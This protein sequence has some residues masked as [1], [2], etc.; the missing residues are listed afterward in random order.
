MKVSV[1]TSDLL[2]FAK[3]AEDTS[4]AMPTVIAQSLNNV[5]N[6]LVA[7]LTT[8]L[9]RDTGLTV[10]QVRGQIRVKRATK[11]DP[12][13][14]VIVKTSLMEDDPRTLEGKRES[15]DF[16]RND[17]RDLVIIVNQ[18]DD[19]VCMDCEELAAAGPMPFDIAKEHIPKHPHCRC[20]IMPF[21]QKGKRLPVT[22]TSTTGTSTA[23][24]SGRE[25]IDITIRQ[26]A[27]RIL[28]KTVTNIKIELK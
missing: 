12:T 8:D 13:Y 19:L 16:G 15:K 2:K 3:K 28:D 17:P 25:N 21:V 23:K 4:K 10:E 27:Q 20:V 18:K 9:A 7:V 26:M 11:T 5:G 1:D 24:R 14:E 22:M 6:G